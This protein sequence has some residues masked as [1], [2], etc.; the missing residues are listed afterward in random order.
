MP[1]LFLQ[2]HFSTSVPFLQAVFHNAIS[3]FSSLQEKL[4]ILSN[5]YTRIHTQMHTQ[6]YIHRV[7]YKFISSATDAFALKIR[8]RNSFILGW[9]L[10]RAREK[11]LM[12]REILC[13]PSQ[14]LICR[15]DVSTGLPQT[16]LWDIANNWH[17]FN[18]L[19]FC[20]CISSEITEKMRQD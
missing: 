17:V 2:L 3:S 19:I 10:V 15:E 4:K 20:Q 13:Q 16:Y 7:V 14:F 6:L 9:L 5:I 1:C 8:K 12:G 11:G 18:M